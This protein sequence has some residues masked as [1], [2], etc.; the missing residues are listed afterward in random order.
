MSTF[1]YRF[2]SD[3][4]QGSN[5]FGNGDHHVEHHPY[6]GHNAANGNGFSTEDTGD[7][8]IQ[9][10]HLLSPT[11]VSALK[12]ASSEALHEAGQG[13]APGEFDPVQAWNQPQHMP[14]PLVPKTSGKYFFVSLGFVCPTSCNYFAPS[15]NPVSPIQKFL[16]T[17]PLQL[18]LINHNLKRMPC[19]TGKSRHTFEHL[20][21]GKD[22]NWLSEIDLMFK[23]HLRNA[24]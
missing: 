19:K 20:A 5:G 16:T 7:H 18:K 8:A 4:S 21:F 13:T 24:A 14:T 3:H 22:Q 11:E 12:T 23:L 17:R 6:D 9:E 10:T 1:S 2:L 15:T